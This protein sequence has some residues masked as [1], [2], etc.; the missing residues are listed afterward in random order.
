MVSASSAT[1][2]EIAR[3]ATWI[4]AVIPRPTSEMVSARVPSLLA[5]IPTDSAWSWLWRVQQP[6]EPAHDPG[7]VRV[8]TVVVFV[9]TVVVPVHVPVIMTV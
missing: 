9:I 5:V 8:I 2:P 4:A 6:S 7:A 1:E 3:I